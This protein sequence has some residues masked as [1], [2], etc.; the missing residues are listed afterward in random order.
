MA[1]VNPDP[2]DGES[3]DG[4]WTYDVFFVAIDVDGNPVQPS[5]AKGVNPFPSQ[6]R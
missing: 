2:K 1:V 5:R 4:R 3:K 6:Q